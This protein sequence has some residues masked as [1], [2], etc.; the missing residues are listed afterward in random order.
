MPLEMVWIIEP[1]VVGFI[2]SG[3]V[4]AHD[5]DEFG[6]LGCGQAAARPLSVL[7]DFSAAKSLPKNLVNTALRSA[8]LLE[9][10]SHP[11]ARRFVFVDVNPAARFMVEMIF[12]NTAVKIAQ[13]RE[14]AITYLKD[15]ADDSGA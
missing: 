1:A 4:T 9:F 5:L 13:T 7:V 11:H 15:A 2:F 6:R 3:D 10:A 8:P 14:T 12:R